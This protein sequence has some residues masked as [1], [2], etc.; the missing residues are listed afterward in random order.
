MPDDENV[1]YPE[2]LNG[3]DKRSLEIRI[4]GRCEICDVAVNEHFARIEIDDLSCRHTTVRAADPEIVG[5][6]LLDQPGE[7]FRIGPRLALN[8]RS[9]ALQQTRK[10]ARIVAGL[11]TRV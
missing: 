8:P 3:E 7:K 1:S 5:T 9:I 10:R 2:N 6:L 4:I 11:R